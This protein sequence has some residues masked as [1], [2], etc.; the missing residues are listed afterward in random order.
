MHVCLPSWL[1]A[2]HSLGQS[3]DN[4]VNYLTGLYKDHF[5]WLNWTDNLLCNMDYDMHLILLNPYITPWWCYYL[6]PFYR[7]KIW[8]TVLCVSSHYILMSTSWRCYCHSPFYRCNIWGWE[9]LRTEGHSSSK[10][11]SADN[12]PAL[13]ANLNNPSIPFDLRSKTIGVDLSV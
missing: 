4:N 6:S 5:S 3:R 7:C 10:W 12:N 13:S 8:W 11:W 9:K 2:L 1:T